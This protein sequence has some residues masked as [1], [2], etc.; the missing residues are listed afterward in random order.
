MVKIDRLLEIIIYLL[1][2]DHVPASYLAERFHVS[3]RTIQGILVLLLMYSVLEFMEAISFDSMYS[4][5][6]LARTGNDEMA[7]GTI[8]AFMAAGCLAASI[9]L[10][11]M[12]Q[13]QRKL[14]MM[15]VVSF[16][17]LV[18]ITLFGMGRKIDGVAN[19]YGSSYMGNIPATSSRTGID[20]I[21]IVS[22]DDT[23]LDYAKG[24][25]AQGTLN[26]VYEDSNK[27]ATVFN[28]NNSLKVG[29]T[30]Q[31]AGTEVEISC[32]L[33]QG[34]FGDDLIVIC[35]QETFERLMGQE[36]YGLIGVQL[37]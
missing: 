18:G 29:D 19:A 6:I 22:Y 9:M 26:E 11:V 24:N 13:P 36:K 25:I 21:N 7:V 34:L 8:A 10:T 31:I 2:H 14:S 5:L 1:N 20:H 35:S 32:A 16:M 33:S 37:E 3:V 23:L 30:I 28:K 12:K 4:P 27:V 15:Y 17:C